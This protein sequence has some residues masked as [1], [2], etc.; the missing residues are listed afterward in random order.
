MKPPIL[1]CSTCGRKSPAVQ[2]TPGAWIA[3]CA[4]HPPMP[5]PRASAKGARKRPKKSSEI[6]PPQTNV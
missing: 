1:A 5:A 6:E 2:I 3:R 4:D